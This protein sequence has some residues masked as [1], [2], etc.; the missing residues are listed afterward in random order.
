MWHY[1]FLTVRCVGLQRLEPDR[2]TPPGVLASIHTRQDK[3][4][5]RGISGDGTRL[6]NTDVGK[7]TV[8]IG[9]REVFKVDIKCSI[10]KQLLLESFIIL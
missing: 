3:T 7:L 4:R 8:V 2:L 9:A 1:A 10:C 5:G 6:A